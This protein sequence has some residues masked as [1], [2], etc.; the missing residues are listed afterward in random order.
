MGKIVNRNYALVEALQ[1]R[2]AF[3]YG[4]MPLLIRT[5]IERL[6]KSGKIRFLICTATLVEGVNLPAK[7]IFLRGP[8]KGQSP[9]NETDFWNL[10]GRA[11]RLGKEFQ[12]NIVCVDPT[13]TSIW[14]TQPPRS[15]SKYTV[16]R[17]LDVVA[18][19]P[20]ELLA[21]IAHGTPRNEASERPD[22]EYAFVYFINSLIK[23]ETLA[24]PYF[25]S[26]YGIKFVSE[27]EAACKNTLESVA[28][29]SELISRNPGVSPIAQQ[30]L[31]KHFQ[32]CAEPPE[33]L[34]PFPPES[35]DA[36]RDSYV[37]IIGVISEH[38]S[39][40][41]Q[42][43]NWPRA[44]LVVNWMRGTALSRIITDNWSYWSTHG[45]TLP[46][47]IR[48][49]MQ[50]IEQFARFKFVKYASCYIDVLKQFFVT[51]NQVGL[52]D[53]IPQLHIFLEFGASIQTQISL[54]DLG[55]SRVSAIAISDYMTG[56]NLSR[57]ECLTW[58]KQQSFERFDLSPIIT[59]ELERLK[60]LVH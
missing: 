3:H 36:V 11:G 26:K 52:I 35:P 24:T 1:K 25:I 49:S 33:S 28:L 10:A 57:N 15:P 29:P 18:L 60:R 38:L 22:L 45:K 6:F 5:E 19:N 54:M 37:K 41:P 27:I 32:T 4:N 13:E 55:L 9:L 46:V 8:K 30:N 7:S 20:A 23:N 53:L 34:I 48:E 50:D 40:D 56:T 16:R 14:K 42:Q 59:A 39:G 47:V 44:I 31:L 58:I 43:L 2:V 17:A 51:T 12:G 21:F